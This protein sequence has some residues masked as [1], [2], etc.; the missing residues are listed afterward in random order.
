MAFGKVIP[1]IP[2]HKMHVA[3]KVPQKTT[4]Q[5]DRFTERKYVITIVQVCMRT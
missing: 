4:K 3:P 5:I 2:A 1:L